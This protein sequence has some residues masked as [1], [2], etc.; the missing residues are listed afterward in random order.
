MS[1]KKESRAGRELRGRIGLKLVY[2]PFEKK[3]GRGLLAIYELA[4]QG[5]K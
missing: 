4:A 3:R 1:S 2:D 5:S